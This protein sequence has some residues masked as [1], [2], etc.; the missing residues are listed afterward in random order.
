MIYKLHALKEIKG[1]RGIHL[2]RYQQTDEVEFYATIDIHF[3][4]VDELLAE[5]QHYFNWN[6]P[7]SAHT[8]CKLQGRFG[9]HQITTISMNHTI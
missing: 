9:T 7:H 2:E 4:N 3:N 5:W 8:R 6:H 1:E